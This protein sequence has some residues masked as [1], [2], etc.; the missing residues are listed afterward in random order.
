MNAPG[1]HRHLLAPATPPLAET[2]LLQ[3]APASAAADAAPE[4]LWLADLHARWPQAGDLSAALQQWQD[5]PPA[6]DRALHRLAQ[7]FALTDVERLAVALALAVDTDPL[8]ARAVGWLQA[9]LRELR[10]TAGL[11][12]ALHAGPGGDAAASLAMLLDGAALRHQLLRLVEAPER[13]LPDTALA[14]PMP[15]VLAARGA[16]GHW[17]GVTLEEPGAALPPSLQREAERQATQ[18]AAGAGALVLRSAHPAEARR[19]AAAVAALL[20]R[21]TA[22]IEGTEAPPGLAA[23]LVLHDALPVFC[24]VL[25]PGER[26]RVPALPA[27]TGPCLLASGPDGNWTLDGEAPAE[28]PLAL[29]TAA[30]RTALWASGGAD[31]ALAAEL[32]ARHRHSAARIA[33]L[34]RAAGPGAL[35]RPA[36]H[37]AARRQRSELGTLAEA[38]P[39]DVPDAALVL[40]APLRAELA[41]LLQRCRLRDGLADG[42]GPGARTRYRPGV[43]AL[44]VG[45]SGTGKT[46]SAGW[47]ATQLSLPLYRV[48]LAAV[49]S[50]YIGE[51]EK[52]LAELFARAEHDEVVLLFDEADALFGKRTEVKDA[53]DRF[54]N[55]QTN[56]LLQRI[57]SYDGIVLLTSNSRARFDSAFTRRLDAILEFP[58]PGPEERRAQWRAH[59]G[60]AHALA[61][62]AL[63]R[64]AAGCELAGGHIR[65]VV[66]AARAVAGGGAIDAP[67]LAAALGA[68]YRKL[69]KSMP[70][71]LLAAGG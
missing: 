68:E 54:A 38:L 10:P 9:P 36:L 70:A 16:R 28:W 7:A 33:A 50:K 53:N 37:Q 56:Y 40:A 64:L 45:A 8:A 4:A 52:N 42:L 18:L 65:N 62:A 47:I 35:Q 49:T 55:Q 27:A 15:V 48:D 39:S 29:P 44:L 57:E 67:A 13:T 17:P 59:L 46:L 51:T 14:L 26:R 69:G 31:A 60:D 63:N 25:A 23:W 20:G 21:R 30:E 3:L 24:A 5:Q 12:A 43:R 34:C 32:G 61:P 1:S 58:A 41:H 66:L 19:A 2:A 6:S 11:V 71:V 22:C